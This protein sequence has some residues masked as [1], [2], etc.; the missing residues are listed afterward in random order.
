MGITPA[1]LYCWQSERAEVSLSLVC[2]LAD[3]WPSYLL[4]NSN[5]L[6]HRV[7]NFLLNK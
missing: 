3:R 5:R 1:I 7:S 2:V 6:Y 4:S